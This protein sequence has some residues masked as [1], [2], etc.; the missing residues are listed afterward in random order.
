MQQNNKRKNDKFPA[1]SIVLLLLLFLSGCSRSGSSGFASSSAIPEDSSAPSS[2]FS[3]SVKYHVTTDLMDL[4]AVNSSPQKVSRITVS[5]PYDIEVCVDQISYFA[6]KPVPYEKYE[7]EETIRQY[8]DSSDQV[9]VDSEKIAQIAD[10]FTARSASIQTIVGKALSWT[11]QNIRYDETL[12]DEIYDGSSKGQSAEETLDCKKGTCNEYS[13][14]FIAFMRHLG[15]PARYVEGFWM[16]DSD[17]RMYHAWAEFYLQGYG[18]VPVDPMNG[19]WGQSPECVKLF[20][21]KDFSDI[22]VKLR[23][24]NAYYEKIG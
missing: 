5:S 13:N 10:T 12:A 11:K 23:D 2:D 21:G 3:T 7:Y 22:N 6:L 9:Q 20:V 17:M 16:T 19:T 24:I 18:W 4:D 14:V 8:V 15:I 1:I